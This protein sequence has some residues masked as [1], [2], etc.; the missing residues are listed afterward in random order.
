M[1]LAASTP[2]LISVAVTP[3]PIGIA[4]DDPAPGVADGAAPGAPAPDT[5]VPAA[6]PVAA[7]PAEA[8][9]VAVSGAPLPLEAADPAA[10]SL[11]PSP[12]D[13]SRVFGRAR[14]VVELHDTATNERHT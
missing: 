11:E 10:A 4:A 13:D 12:P 9:P 3:T 7:P 6:V 1:S 2:I 8:E 14:R 5:L